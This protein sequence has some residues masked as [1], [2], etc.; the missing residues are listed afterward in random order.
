M[1]RSPKAQRL[2]I[3]SFFAASLAAWDLPTPDQKR[4]P[5]PPRP[6]QAKRAEPS[7]ALPLRPRQQAHPSQLRVAPPSQ[8]RY[9]SMQR[10]MVKAE[11]LSQ[12]MVAQAAGLSTDQR[13]E[14]AKKDNWKLMSIV[15]F[16]AI[17]IFVVLFFLFRYVA[18]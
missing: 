14:A 8:V 13:F 12:V 11:D 9:A 6:S 10:P 2:E 7:R 18:I 5:T 17:W 15:G 3:P 4:I 1:D 16:F